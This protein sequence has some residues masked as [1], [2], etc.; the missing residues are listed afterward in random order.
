MPSIVRD[1][2]SGVAMFMVPRDAAQ[3]LVA[4]D[5]FEVVEMAP[6]ETQLVLGFVDYR[7]NDLGDYDEVMIVFMVR[8]RGTNEPE[9]TYIY[10]LPVNQSFT[11]EAGSKIWG[12]PKTVDEIDIGYEESRAT[13]RLVMSG[14]H[15]F[16]LGIPRVVIEDGQPDIEMVTYTHIDGPH[17]VPFTSG[18]KGMAVNIG[19]EGVELTLG[20]HR[21]ADELRALGLPKPALMSTWTEH[22]TGSFGAPRR[23]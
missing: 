19:S 5:A 2:S 8:P 16:T 22:M 4:R 20:S 1:A 10:K 23:L 21:I 15:V 12:F 13:C 11:C 14:Q 3:R 17:A 6:G 7:D 9:G 18:G